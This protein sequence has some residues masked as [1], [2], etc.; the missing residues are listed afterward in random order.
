MTYPLPPLPPHLNV[1]WYP[2]CGIDAY[3]LA[4]EQSLNRAG[5]RYAQSPD[6]LTQ[7]DDVLLPF[8]C[9]PGPD[10]DDRDFGH[11]LRAERQPYSD[12][13]GAT[14]LRS[15]CCL[16]NQTCTLSD[17]SQVILDQMEVD[18]PGFRRRRFFVHAACTAKQS[19]ELIASL[20]WNIAAFASVR[21]GGGFSGPNIDEEL[22]HARGMGLALSARLAF[23]DTFHTR[24]LLASGLWRRV[25]S[26]RHWGFG[27]VDLLQA[28]TQ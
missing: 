20:G 22:G 7:R 13:L 3:A 26:H 11:R 27:C 24:G 17:G 19:L 9:D 23:V 28:S 6:D 2:G 15:C 12:L 16:G 18:L 14:Q 5:F 25:E 1:L 8:Y 10:W 4:H 21:G